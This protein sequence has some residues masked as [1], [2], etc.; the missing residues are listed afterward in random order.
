MDPE[1][2][3]RAFSELESSLAGE[4]R[5]PTLP[6]ARV[7]GL[8]SALNQEIGRLASASPDA[9]IPMKE[10]QNRVNAVTLAVKAGRWEEAKLA[11]R[12]ARAVLTR[13]L[14]PSQA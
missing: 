6:V 9:V 1:S 8:I 7:L 10:L 14:K 4:D 11:M 3:R 12:G 2:L 5:D 13:L